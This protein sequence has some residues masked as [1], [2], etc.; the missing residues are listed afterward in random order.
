MI[1]SMTGFGRADMRINGFLIQ[2]EVRTVN[3]RFCDVF[4]KLPN[5]YQHY[6]AELRVFIQSK[7]KRGK[8]N[9]SVKIEETG[10]SKSS[11]TLNNAL[12]NQ[13]YDMLTD[14]SNDLGIKETP[15]LSQ[16]LQFD[17]IF[18]RQ[19]F[20]KKEEEKFKEALYECVEASIKQTIQ[21]R[22]EEGKV[23]AGDLS[24]RIDAIEASSK[25]INDIAQNRTEEARNRLHE[26]IKVLLDDDKFDKDRLEMEIAILADKMDITEEVVR[27]TSHL[28]F[29]RDS[30]NGNESSGRKLNFLLQEM[31]R[32]INTIGSKAYSSEIAH[33]VVEI[34]EA[35][36]QIRE[37]VQNIA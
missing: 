7:F 1:E 11:V 14:L 26:R 35:L 16:L 2:S 15:T 23:L 20:T 6:E 3:N 32:E 36:E 5:E 18:S 37:Q 8:V 33:K 25:Q 34:K 12:A 29:F 21:M 17:D 27:L 22:M 28:K 10:G 24:E 4:V 31:L 30:M 13:Y 9:A 19:D